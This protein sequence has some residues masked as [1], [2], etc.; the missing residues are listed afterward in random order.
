MNSDTQDFF[1]VSISD[2]GDYLQ[3]NKLRFSISLRVRSLVAEM[4]VNWT[5][6]VFSVIIDI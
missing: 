5:T 2:D 3:N 1:A 6:E 4:S